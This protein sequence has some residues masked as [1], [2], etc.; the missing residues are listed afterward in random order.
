M[1]NAGAALSANAWKNN[2]VCS[3]STIKFYIYS[4]L[5]ERKFEIG[6]GADA[7]TQFLCCRDKPTSSEVLIFLATRI[8]LG[9]LVFWA[10]LQIAFI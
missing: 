7:F 10:Y 4:F 8:M 3:S 2:Q 1:K 6:E 5:K 9:G